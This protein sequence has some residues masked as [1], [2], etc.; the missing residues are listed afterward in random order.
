MQNGLTEI[1]IALEL[2]FFGENDQNHRKFKQ[3]IDKNISVSKN[4]PLDDKNSTSSSAYNTRPPPRT[5]PR[6]TP[7]PRPTS[8]PTTRAPYRPPTRPPTRP[9]QRPHHNHPHYPDKRGFNGT[10]T[11][12]KP[13][14][15]EPTYEGDYDTVT[16]HRK[17][18]GH[19]TP[20]FGGQTT[21]E[22]AAASSS[23]TLRTVTDMT[24]QRDGVCEGSFDAVAMVRGEI[25]VVKGQ[26]SWILFAI[27]F[28]KNG[29]QLY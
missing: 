29:L 26:V 16:S 24:A 1:K 3:L 12:Q 13:T 23:T 7:T 2:V 10:S 18:F 8:A 6:T 27:F 15:Y 11:T 9:T 22:A 19:S 17:K 21:A 20:A 14:A 25:F 4:L 5:T 28:F